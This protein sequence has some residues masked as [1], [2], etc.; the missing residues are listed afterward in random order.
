MR[1][2]ALAT[3]FIYLYWGIFNTAVMLETPP[4][5]NPLMWINCFLCAALGLWNLRSL[6]S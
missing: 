2:V 5:L 6:R 1:G 4:R 3:A